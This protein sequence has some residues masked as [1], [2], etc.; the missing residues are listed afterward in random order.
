MLRLLEL[1]RERIKLKWGK[2]ERLKERAKREKA[3]PRKKE[4]SEDEV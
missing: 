1:S 2:E 3:M 4:E